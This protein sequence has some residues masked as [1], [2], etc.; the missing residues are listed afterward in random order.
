MWKELLQ[1]RRNR[2]MLAVIFV[3]PIIQTFLFSYA[4]STDVSHITMAVRDMDGTAESRALVD[5]FLASGYFTYRI[6]ALSD[7]DVNRALDTGK[8]Q[9][10]LVIPRGFAHDLAR[11]RTGEVQTLLDGSDSVT[12]NIIAGYTA[13]ITQSY[14]REIGLARLDRLR[15]TVVSL[16]GLEPRPRVW[17]NPELKSVN[18]M[19]P[20]VLCLILTLVTLLLTAFSVVREKEVGTLEQLVVTPLTPMELMIGKTLPFVL[21]GLLDMALVLGVSIVWFHIHVAGS[22][23]LLFACAG[24]YVLT[25]LGLGIFVSTV[26]R[27][28]QE[29]LL[30]A[31]F[32]FLPSIILSGFMFPVENMPRIVQGLTYVIPLRYFLEIVRGICL[33]GNGLDILWPQLLILAAF[34][35][36]ILAAASARFHKH[37][38]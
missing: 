21:I 25:T 9:M 27:T 10:V 20:G 31:F 19:V 16:P 11:G 6:Q 7:V 1:T 28:Q 22:V 38:G 4:V 26:S 24:V 23:W 35:A 17:Y 12:A 18:F 33:K 37:L 2:M 14:A 34:A 15:A 3:S 36:V 13:Q 5:R 32:I 30:T 29:A 8:A